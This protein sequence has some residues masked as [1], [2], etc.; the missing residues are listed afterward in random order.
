MQLRWADGPGVEI[1][2]QDQLND[3]LDVLLA[4][5]AGSEPLVAYLTG[6][7]GA[8]GLGLDP[9]GGGLL[10]FAASGPGRRTLHCV[11]DPRPAPG[12]WLIR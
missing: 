6:G 8:L 1:A 7:A 2:G 10:L 4:G 12:T 3:A 5:P 9:D 11:G